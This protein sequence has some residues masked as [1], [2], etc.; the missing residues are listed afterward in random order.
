MQKA[1]SRLMHLFFTLALLMFAAI[2]LISYKSVLHL[3]GTIRLRSHSYQ[4]LALLD[5]LLYEVASL[6]SAGRGY[7]ITGDEALLGPYRNAEKQ[8]AQVLEAMSTLSL[9]SQDQQHSLA[10]LRRLVDEKL[11]L[12][13]QKVEMVRKGR[14]D[15][16]TAL[17]R[18]GSGYDLM[19]RIHELVARMKTG[20]IQ[21]LARREADSHLYARQSAFTLVLGTLLSVLILG[22]V[23]FRLNQEV[24]RR[25]L[26]EL[27][28]RKMNDEL[29]DRVEQRTAA[30]ALANAQLG[31]RN[32]EI[33]RASRMKTEFLAR[34]SHELRTPLNAISGFADLLAEE[35]AG[36]LSDKQKRFVA[37]IQGGA[38]HL[39]N[40]INEILDLSKIEAG[41]IEL[42]HEDFTVVSALTDVLATTAPLAGARSIQIDCAV[43]DSLSVRADRVRFQQIL[44][45]LLSNAIKYTPEGGRIWIQSSVESGFAVLRV[46]DTGI[47]IP[48]NQQDSI[49]HEF[50]RTESLS[51][52]VQGT[53]LGLAITR[54]LVELHGGRI[55]VESEV[56]R[57]STFSFTLPL[58][59]DAMVP[60]TAF[61]DRAALRTRPLVLFIEPDM[62]ARPALVRALGDAGLEGIPLEK[63]QDLVTYARALRPDAIIMHSEASGMSGWEAL[64]DL[65]NSDATKSL[66]ILVIAH[67]DRRQ[68]A[69]TMGATECVG[70]P[71]GANVLAAAVLRTLNAARAARPPQTERGAE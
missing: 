70:S 32:E 22:T 66:P 61:P 35:S 21:L 51:K 31:Q 5:R 71:A 19:N 56:G 28:I 69:L 52:E 4:Q 37:R 43:E 14:P 53:G 55:W 6:E 27:E 26:S 58:S 9:D 60:E 47:G 13:R 36:A 67:P 62:G 15:E 24:G 34:I 54:R 20:E 59:R 33:E 49:F 64:V 48:A 42:K 65:R 38:A 57:G 23:Y 7:V 41:R 29:E 3:A 68:A 11:R 18:A 40:L 1:E 17:L 44:Y 2:A 10:E 8:L 16:A 12:H 46:K 45:N 50:H 39:L 30:L 63:D 25:R